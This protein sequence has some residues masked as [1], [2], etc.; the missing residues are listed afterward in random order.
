MKMDLK[1]LVLAALVTLPTVSS[2]T[3]AATLYVDSNNLA[4]TDLGS[5]TPSAPY[6]T[7]LAA[8][9]AAGPGTTILV[10]PGV[11][12][13][14]V[15]VSN[16][17]ASGN[18]LVIQA[19]GAPV[20][21]DG[22]DD[23]SSPS[24][25]APV[26]GNVW[27]ASS[28][29]WPPLQVFAD[30]VRLTS[31]TAPPAALPSGSFEYVGGTGLYVNAGGGNPA[32]HR[33]AVGHRRFGFH[34]SGRSWVT[35]DGFVVTRQDDKAIFAEAGSSHVTISRNT[36]SLSQ[37]NGIAAFGCDNMLV[38]SNVV[39]L[40]S[41]H[42]ISFRLGTT[43]ST[44]QDNKSFDNVRTDVHFANGIYLAG[45]PANLIQRNQLHGND[46]T[47]LEIQSGSNNCVSLQNVSFSNGDH[48]FEHLLATGTVNVGNVAWGNHT[49]GFSLEGSATGTQIQDCIAVDNGLTVNEFDFYVDAGSA[50]D[51]VSD[52]NIFWN[53]TSQAP[54]KYGNVTYPLLSSFVTASGHD[55]HST[56]AN[57]RFLAPGAGDFGLQAGSPAIDAGTSLAPNWPATDAEDHSRVDDVAT[58][59]TGAGPVPYTDRGAFEF[60]SALVAVDPSLSLARVRLSDPVPN[61]A[62]NRVSLVLGLPDASHLEWGVFDV[63]GRAIW[64]ESREVG[65]GATELRWL[66]T[67]ASAPVAAGLYFVRVQVPGQVVVR[68]FV[69]LH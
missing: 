34:I 55:S 24:Q 67:Q 12:R 57:P 2:E 52:Y 51:L 47:G 20:V 63:G 39:S 66:R 61:P 23:F 58:P 56:Q 53:S 14:E 15:N 36:V 22:A 3:S 26:S 8:V 5:G 6:C 37:S 18:P 33:T 35:I 16:S 11:Y 9:A 30:G 27:L 68:R 19:L 45:S 29:S 54:I 46:D 44:I 1:V 43:A 69:I 65:A 38:A 13:E 48:G 62:S 60:Q 31:S 25:W 50:F 17:G 7:I 64:S 59:N 4:C 41:H 28:V 49:D 32:A 40:V 21:V 42:G 10:S